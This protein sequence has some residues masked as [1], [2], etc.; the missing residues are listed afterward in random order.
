MVKVPLKTV[1]YFMR[2]KISWIFKQ[3]KVDGSQSLK[4]IKNKRQAWNFIEI[5]TKAEFSQNQVGVF[6]CSEKRCQCCVKLLLHNSYT[7]K[8]VD[9]TFKSHPHSICDRANLFY[10]VIALHVETGTDQTKLRDRLRFFRK[11]IRHPGDQNLK[12]EEHLRTCDK[13]TF[14]NC[15]LIYAKL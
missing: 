5:I 6:K 2:R 11:H 14:K 7:F 9:K 4:V 13:G 3:S 8:N 15:Y 10:V 1:I 12:V